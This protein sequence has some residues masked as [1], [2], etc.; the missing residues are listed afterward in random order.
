VGFIYLDVSDATGV[1]KLNS[2]LGGPGLV[3]KEAGK[4]VLP[5]L[6]GMMGLVLPNKLGWFFSV[7]FF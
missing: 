5:R 7:S 1:S 4:S 6:N 2:D 3:V